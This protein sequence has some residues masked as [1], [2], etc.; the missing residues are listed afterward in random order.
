MIDYDMI[1]ENKFPITLESDYAFGEI[2]NVEE[3]EDLLNDIDEN[4][5]VFV[6]NTKLFLEDDSVKIFNDHGN[7]ITLEKYLLE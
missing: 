1:S 4:Y 2:F 5:Q 3:L 7:G 6:L